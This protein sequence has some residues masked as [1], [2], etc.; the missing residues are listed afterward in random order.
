MIQRI[1]T[2]YLAIVAI[3]SSVSLFSV[4]ARFTNSADNVAEFTNFSFSTLKEPFTA[5][6]CSGPWALGCILILVILL[7]IATIF[8]FNHRIH[9]LRLTIFNTILLVGYVA[10]YAFFA[11]LYTN[12][13]A[14]IDAKANVEFQLCAM[15]I[16]PVI[17]IILNIM[18]IHN[19]RKD[20]RLVRSLDRIR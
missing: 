7:T 13:L 10:V 1:Q 6:S 4:I 12:K 5:L 17:S 2:L 14:V 19:I 9:Q 8:M 3:L 11:W 16:F 20:E 15:A 18:A